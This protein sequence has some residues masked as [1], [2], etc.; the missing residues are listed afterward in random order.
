[1]QTVEFYIVST[2]TNKTVETKK[3][4]KIY[5]IFTTTHAIQP[6]SNE[7]YLYNEI[8]HLEKEKKLTIN[9]L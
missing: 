4:Q 3:K 6:K 9:I 5:I 7:Q 8:N 1:M 2:I